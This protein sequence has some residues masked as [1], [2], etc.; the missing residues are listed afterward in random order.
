MNNR[1]QIRALRGKE[2][3]KTICS[4]DTEAGVLSLMAHGYENYPEPQWYFVALDGV[5]LR[6]EKQLLS[7]YWEDVTMEKVKAV[8]PQYDIEKLAN[9]VGGKDNFPW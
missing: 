2:I 9:A 4:V 3:S 8:Y 1:E 7:D 5:W 6:T